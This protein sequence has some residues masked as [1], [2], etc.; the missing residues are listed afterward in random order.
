MD[1]QV[2]SLLDRRNDLQA[3]HRREGRCKWTPSGRPGRPEGRG[4]VGPP[5]LRDGCETLARQSIESMP[6]G[7]YVNRPYTPDTM[8][9]H[10]Y[11]N[12]DPPQPHRLRNGHSG[13]EVVLAGQADLVYV[14][15]ETGEPLEVI[16]KLLPLT[17]SSSRLPRGRA[18]GRLPDVRQTGAEG[19]QLLDVRASAGAVHIP[20]E[21]HE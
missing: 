11:P 14:D 20:D 21:E 6:A 3:G 10:S 13:R 4:V 19:P 7:S 8:Y 16:G 17:P 5:R 15:G 12:P 18:P 2:Q 1:C 9:H